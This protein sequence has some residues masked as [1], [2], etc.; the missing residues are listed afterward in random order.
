[1]YIH[2]NILEI[3]GRTLMTLTQAKTLVVECWDGRH[4]DGILG[5]GGPDKD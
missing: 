4:T 5:E 1:M 3:A 2:T